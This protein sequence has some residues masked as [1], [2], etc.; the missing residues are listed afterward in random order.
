ME[1]ATVNPDKYTVHE[2][3]QSVLHLTMPVDQA[4]EFLVAMIGAEYDKG[5]RQGRQDYS[6]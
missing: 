1:T 6:P 5:Y 4:E 2:L 3:L